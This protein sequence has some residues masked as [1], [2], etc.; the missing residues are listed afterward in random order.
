MKPLSTNVGVAIFS[1]MLHLTV[2]FNEAMRPAVAPAEAMAKLGNVLPQLIYAIATA[3]DGK[4]PILFSKL[5]VKD[6]YWRMVV[7]QKDKWHF[8]YVLPKASPDV[9]TQLVIPLCL[10][11]GWCDSPSYFCTTSE[12]ARDVA[13]MLAAAQPMGSLASHPLEGYLVPPSK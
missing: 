7:P 4:G 9:P 5:D 11:M 2:E 13:E 12:T 6:G 10:Q 8:V 3:P 1:A